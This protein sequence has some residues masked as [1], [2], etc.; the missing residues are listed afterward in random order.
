MGD[1]QFFI[2]FLC[3]K[4]LRGPY[5]GISADHLFPGA[6]GT[7]E[8]L[9]IHSRVIIAAYFGSWLKCNEGIP[10]YGLVDGRSPPAPITPTHIYY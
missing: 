2:K 10:R 1:T 7:I 5:N 4:T 8:P 3:N 9:K 6:Q